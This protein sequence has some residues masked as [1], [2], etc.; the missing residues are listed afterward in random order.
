MNFLFDEIWIRIVDENFIT[1][2]ESVRRGGLAE[3][4]LQVRVRRL[5]TVNLFLLC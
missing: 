2:S 4:S 1:I 5:K 3:D